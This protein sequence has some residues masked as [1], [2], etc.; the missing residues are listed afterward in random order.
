MDSLAEVSTAVP[1]AS[2]ILQITANDR[3][4]G[5]FGTV[6]IVCCNVEVTFTI[7]CRFDTVF[8]LEVVLSLVSK[9]EP[10]LSSRE[11]RSQMTTGKLTH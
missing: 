10:G 6:R 2:R 4:S 8:F 1:T 3:D 7:L 9:R 11:E 5:N